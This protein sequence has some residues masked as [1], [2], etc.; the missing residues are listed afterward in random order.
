MTCVPNYVMLSQR[1][2]EN[3]CFLDQQSLSPSAARFIRFICELT[4]KGGV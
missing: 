3:Y 1:W 2:S 4:G